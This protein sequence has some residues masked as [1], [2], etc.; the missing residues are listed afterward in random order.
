MHY[1]IPVISDAKDCDNIPSQYSEN[2]SNILFGMH[3]V[4]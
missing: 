2:K 3:C 4:Y 1:C